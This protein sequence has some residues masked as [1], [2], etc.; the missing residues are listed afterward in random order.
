[1][2]IPI[3]LSTEPF[4]RDRPVLVA[5]GAVAVVL[6]LLLEKWGRKN[7]D[8]PLCPR[9]AKA[10]LWDRVGCPHFSIEKN[11]NADTD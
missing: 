6:T 8:S 9:S 2:R 11:F 1:M 10:A 5:S 4:Q 7:G 3:N